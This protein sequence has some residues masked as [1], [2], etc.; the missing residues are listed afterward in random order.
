MDVFFSDL[1]ERFRA[2]ISL[3]RFKSVNM[4][5]NRDGKTSMIMLEKCLLSFKFK[6]MFWTFIWTLN[7]HREINCSLF[8]LNVASIVWTSSKIQ[9]H[10]FIKLLPTQPQWLRMIH[11]INPKQ[12]PIHKRSRT[13]HKRSLVSLKL[14]P[15]SSSAWSFRSRFLRSG[16]CGHP[17]RFPFHLTVTTHQNLN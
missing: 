11:V 7:L 2:C 15:I 10:H 17:D 14:N 3:V 5:I 16:C 8:E 12:I 1:F 4:V 6:Q 9:R 13:V